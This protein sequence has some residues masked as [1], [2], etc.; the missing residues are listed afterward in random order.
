MG[1][2]IEGELYRGHAKSAF[3]VSYTFYEEIYP[4]SVELKGFFLH[5]FVILCLP[6][7]QT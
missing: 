4:D 5:N 2:A 1:E 6:E 7:I 3:L